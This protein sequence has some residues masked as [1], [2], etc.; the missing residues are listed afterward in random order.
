MTKSTKKSRLAMPRDREE[1]GELLRQIG[2]LVSDAAAIGAH[3]NAKIGVLAAAM[4]TE[5]QPLLDEIVAIRGALKRWADKK[6][7][8]IV[9]P[10]TKTVKL[11]TGELSWRDT[12]EALGLIEG[13]DEETV[14]ALLKASGFD[15]AVRT[16]EQLDKVAIKQIWPHLIED[17]RVDGLR[18][19]TGEVFQI[20][21]LTLDQPI[22]MKTRTVNVV[23]EL[24]GKPRK[25]KAA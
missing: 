9:E 12:P 6:R 1:A 16:V 14:V 8:E 5:Q 15:E 7:A 4:E 3:Y 11:A 23:D 21:P 25:G 22:E 2:Q 17:G 10:G 13:V 20:K 19:V 24:D 18:L